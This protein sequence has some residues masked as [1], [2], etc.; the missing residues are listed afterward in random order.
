MI[1]S[2]AAK[3][4]LLAYIDALE[5]S[6]DPVPLQERINELEA[7]VSAQSQEIADL[8]AILAQINALSAP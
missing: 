2:A 7:V 4:E 5:T 8:R 6:V 1:F 3:A